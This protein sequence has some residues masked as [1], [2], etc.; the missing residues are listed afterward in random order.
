[1]GTS[2]FPN[3]SAEILI[4]ENQYFRNGKR[5]TTIFSELTLLN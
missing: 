4:V 5:K 2:I 1:M 3:F